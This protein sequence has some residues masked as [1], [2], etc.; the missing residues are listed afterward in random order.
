MSD[1]WNVWLPKCASGFSLRLV[2]RKLE[3]IGQSDR[4]VPSLA[5]S[6]KAFNHKIGK[7]PTGQLART[8]ITGCDH[9]FNVQWLL[10]RFHLALRL[11]VPSHWRSDCPG[12]SFLSSGS[13]IQMAFHSLWPPLYPVREVQ[14]GSIICLLLLALRVIYLHILVHLAQ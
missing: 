2:K 8:Q 1:N 6:F 4:N 5:V 7:W 12:Q 10:P 9:M 14:L 3:I 13:V 11:Q